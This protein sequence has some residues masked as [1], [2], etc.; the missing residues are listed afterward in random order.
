V[1]R[2][3]IDVGVPAQ[4]VWGIAFFAF[5]ALLLIASLIVERILDAR[6]EGSLKD[7]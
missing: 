6:A 7:S 3:L 2:A 1:I 4:I 5:G